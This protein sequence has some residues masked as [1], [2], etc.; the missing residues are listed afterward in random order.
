MSDGNSVSWKAYA[1]RSRADT[2]QLFPS[3][4]D[5]TDRNVQLVNAIL[6]QRIVNAKGQLTDVCR[7]VKLDVFYHAPDPD[8][9]FLPEEEAT[10]AFKQRHNYSASRNET[11]LTR[12]FQRLSVD[13]RQAILANRT[14]V[15][16]DID[17][18]LRS[19]PEC[20][21]PRDK[22]HDVSPVASRTMGYL[23]DRGHNQM[24]LEL[25]A[26]RAKMGP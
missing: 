10:K 9:D 19:R 21:R 18:F 15:F 14:V 6:R 8:G 25:M 4:V 7:D 5:I 23:M 16:A 2:A 20:Y 17:D 11:E 12:Y 3:K 24:V 1:D 13:D 26:L 22:I